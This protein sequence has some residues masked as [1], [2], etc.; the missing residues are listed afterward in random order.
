MDWLIKIKHK[1]FLGEY[2]MTW[3]YSKSLQKNLSL[4]LGGYLI[5]SLKYYK[6]IIFLAREKF[7]AL[8]FLI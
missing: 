4:I 1:I 8:V 7:K 3:L 5:F 6:N 2:S